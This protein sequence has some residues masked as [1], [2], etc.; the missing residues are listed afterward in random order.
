MLESA[1][2]QEGIVS[3]VAPLDWLCL[4][5]G[6]QGH[7]ATWCL[8]DVRFWLRLASL[9]RPQERNCMTQGLPV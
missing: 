9:L 6:R 2:D 4:H 3:A 8:L 1:L 5:E 7:M